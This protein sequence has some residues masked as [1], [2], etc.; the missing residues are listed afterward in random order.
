[1]PRPALAALLAVAACGATTRFVATNPSPRPLAPRPAASVQV[2]TSG[3]P[4]IPYV[5]VG[6]LQG[7]QGG[8]IV[9]GADA[10]PAIVSRMRADAAAIGCDALIVNADADRVEGPGRGPATVRGFWA[11]CIVF[12]APERAA[13]GATAPGATA[14]ASP[15]VTAAP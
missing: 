14:D 9:T 13:P 4:T 6:L 15:A 7:R 5:E 3:Q 2:F 12:L 10:L 11:A 1:M 8:P